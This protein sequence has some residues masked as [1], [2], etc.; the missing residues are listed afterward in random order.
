MIPGLGGTV[1]RGLLQ[2]FGDPG[3]IFEASLSDLMDVGGVRKEIARKIVDKEFLWDPDEEWRKVESCGARV[4]AFHD[5]GYPRYLKELRYPPIVL[6]G[7]GSDI[8]SDDNLIAVVGSRNP[9]HYGLNAAERIGMGLA[10]R[11]VGVVSGMARGIDAAAHWGC[12]RAGGFPIAVLGTGID[13]VYPASNRKLWEQVVQ[14]GLVVTEFPMGTPPEP[15]NFPIRNRIIS[16]LSR[17]VVV[18]E[19][20]KKSG[21]LITATFA[22]DQGRDVFAVPGSIDSFKSTGT[23]MLIKQGAKLV[24]N[25]DD[26]LEEFEAVSQPA[27]GDPI[28]GVSP[29]L[30]SDVDPRERRVLEIVGEYPVHIDHIVRMA[31]MSAGEVLAILLKLELR[32]II[33]QLPGKLFV[34]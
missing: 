15:R 9:T 14:H 22:L 11:G 29:E 5:S 7:K 28:S 27:S 2:H 16:G 34:R 31:E 26:I 32:G 3:T 21:S 4:I 23:H 6:Y 12:L 17:G 24:E 20:S 18:V 10:M 8:P 19:A 30:P 25:A 33:R 1:V 13:V